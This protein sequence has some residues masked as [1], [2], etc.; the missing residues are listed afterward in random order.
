[1]RNREI[2]QR[3]LLL[4]LIG[5]LLFIVVNS[6]LASSGSSYAIDWFEINSGA[7]LAGNGFRLTGIA[8]Q[9]DAGVMSEDSY[10]LGGGFFV[11]PGKEV[12]HQV[13]LPL[14]LRNP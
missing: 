10:K 9:A 12:L 8:G 3:V 4:A 11:E 6:T 7:V 1:M 2:W 13:F 5:V 14:V